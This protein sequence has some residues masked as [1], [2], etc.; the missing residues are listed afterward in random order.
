MYDAMVPCKKCGNKVPSSSLKLDLDLKM[1]VCPDCIK[2]KKIHKEI[3]EEALHKKPAAQMQNQ[4][5][6]P[7]IT[8]MHSEEPKSGKIA[9]KCTSC[10]YKF[11]ID[12]ETKI[13]KNCPY[14][15]A[16]VMGF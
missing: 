11:K 6:A 1:M 7:Q 15:N 4:S 2:N 14:C 10:G 3:E 8:V 9:H 12:P 16:R 5:S 13:P